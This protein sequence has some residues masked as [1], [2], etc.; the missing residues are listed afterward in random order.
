MTEYR[1]IKNLPLLRLTARVFP[2]K[3][4]LNFLVKKYLADNSRLAIRY[5]GKWHICTTVTNLNR[6][7][8]EEVI[9]EGTFSQPEI[10]LIR[11]LRKELPGN[12]SLVDVGG[13]IGSFFCQFLDKCQSVTVF[14][15]IPRLNAV[16]RNSIS[17]NREKKVTLVEKAAGDAPGTV[18]M[19][20]N[21]NSTVV[22]GHTSE[23]IIAIQVTTLD[24]ELKGLS[25]IDFIKIDVEGYEM[26]VLNGARELIARH[27]PIFLVE[28]HPMYLEGFGQHHTDLIR[29]FEELGYRITYYS[30]LIEQR[31][32]R[33][34]RI[35]SRW[36]GNK[37]IKFAGKEEYMK[38]V[39]TEPRLSSYH[40]YCEPA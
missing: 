24:H 39:L 32:P 40:F 34:T 22:N 14:E 13:N 18:K 28:V 29:F 27:R 2:L 21:N 6:S 25:K 26:R 3:H 23:Q 9:L 30:F 19:L 5:S 10:A 38:D 16:I 15:P 8:M 33:S 37:G 12:M 20:D 31:M 36:L 17:Y 7:T 1:T 35:L 11:K 4:K